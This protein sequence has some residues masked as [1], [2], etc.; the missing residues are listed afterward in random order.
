MGYSQCS[1]CS[2]SVHEHGVWRHCR[3]G[4]QQLCKILKFQLTII[5]YSQKQ[6]T[7]KQLPVP[8]TYVKNVPVPV[9]YEWSNFAIN[10]FV[11]VFSV[12]L[13]KFEKKVKM[14]W[15][16]ES[17]LKKLDESLSFL[18]TTNPKSNI[19]V[20]NLQLKSW[21]YKNL[22]KD[23]VPGSKLGTI[24]IQPNV[25]QVPVYDVPVR[26][27]DQHNCLYQHSDPV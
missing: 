11:T 9:L 2:R 16:E 1:Q 24:W 10:I 3:A 26:F 19:M 5:L 21:S 7:G 20:S 23:L 17:Y 27:E 14:I 6:S 13:S 4:R 18:L 25:Y 22:H 15:K 8:I 12:E